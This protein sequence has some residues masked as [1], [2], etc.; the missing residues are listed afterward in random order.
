VLEILEEEEEINMGEAIRVMQAGCSNWIIEM[1]EILDNSRWSVVGK[2]PPSIYRVPD[3]IKRGNTEAYR[4]KL[5]S[6]G[7]L[8]YGEDD[9]VP[10][11]RHK[12]EAVLQRV[13]RFGKPLVEYVAAIQEIADELLDQYHNLDG[14]WR[15]QGREEFVQM[16]V[17]DGCFLLESIERYFDYP[18]SNPVFSYHGC[19]TMYT[20]IRS[21]IILMENQ[22]PLL[23]LHSI[24][25]IERDTAPVSIFKY[26]Q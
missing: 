13:K 14:K 16:M 7:P 25:A 1:E 17:L 9:L 20:A 11:E 12:K 15:T 5:V 3:Q 19:L 24:L 2:K 23:V 6:M 18:A 22:L 10:M 4:P 8:H 26:M 21:D